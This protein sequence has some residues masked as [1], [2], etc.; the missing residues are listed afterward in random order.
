MEKFLLHLHKEKDIVAEESKDRGDG[1]QTG[2]KGGEGISP[3]AP[4]GFRM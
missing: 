1:W 3:L 2:R 4:I